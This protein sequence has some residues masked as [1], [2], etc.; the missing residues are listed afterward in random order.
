[1]ILSDSKACIEAKVLPPANP[2]EDASWVFMVLPKVV[3]ETLPRRGR[4]SVVGAI[5]LCSR[6][7]A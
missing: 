1:M 5:N 3:S 7:L 6:R 2:G 4:T